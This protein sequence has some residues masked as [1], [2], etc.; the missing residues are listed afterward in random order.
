MSRLAE[1]LTMAGLSPEEAAGKAALF[2]AAEARFHPDRQ[3]RRWFV[4]GR[5]EVAGKHTDYAGGQSLVCAAERGICVVAAAVPEPFIRAV[6]LRAAAG[7]R[8]VVLPIGAHSLPQDQ[9]HWAEYA[10]AV[11]ERLQRNYPGALRGVEIALA[12]DLP[13]AAGL[14]SSSALTIAVFVALLGFSDCGRSPNFSAVRSEIELIEY[15]GCV[16]NGQTFQ[17]AAGMPL[18]GG[19]G[20]GTFGGSE[21]HAAI[22]LSQPGRLAQFQFCPARL[23]EYVPMPHDWVFAVA[24]SGIHAEKTGPAR[25]SYNRASL[26]ARTVLE[27]WREFAGRP[28]AS[29]GEAVRSGAET[30]ERIRK[31][32]RASRQAEFSAEELG[33][34]FEHFVFESEQVVPRVAA[35]F[36]TKDFAALGQ[37]MDASQTQAER[38]LKNQTA[39]TVFLARMARSLGAIAASSFGAGFGGSVWAVVLRSDAHA[40]LEAWR[41]DYSRR[42]PGAASE[43]EFFT[44]N[45]G[46]GMLEI[47]PSCDI[48]PAAQTIY[49]PRHLHK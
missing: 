25:D 40:F 28:V 4:P 16:E 17:G 47:S 6:D 23:Q 36:R 42:F 41:V 9:P 19:A 38:L 15:L 18:E 1:Q 21:D 5:I 7:A 45:A 46:P 12:S 13:R 49:A 22:C 20:V 24:S 33:D 30:C 10:A 43:A 14:S 39:E 8:E 35:A 26:A 34:R 48:F 44:T 37:A 29:L 2:A 11:H 3:T 27:T 31:T 32:L